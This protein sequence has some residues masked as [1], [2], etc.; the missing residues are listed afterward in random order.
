MQMKLL[1]AEDNAQMR[2]MIRR[3][4]ADLAADI[5]ECED[6]AEAVALYQTTHPDWVLMDLEMPRMNGLLATQAILRTDPT[7]RVLIV[8]N[9]ND[10]SLRQ[11]ATAAGV[12]GYVLKENLFD[13]RRWL[14]A[15]TQ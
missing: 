6:G 4:V 8:T 14:Q 5:C 2:Q 10:D 11:A 1:I 9:H 3:I 13:L 12:C 15:D 7:A